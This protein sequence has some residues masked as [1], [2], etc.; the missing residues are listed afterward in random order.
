MI[1]E[2]NGCIRLT[3]HEADI[4]RQLLRT[5]AEVNTIAWTCAYC[6]EPHE[7]SALIWPDVKYRLI[8]SAC[9]CQQ[10]YPHHIRGLDPTPTPRE[11]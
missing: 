8:C 7:T 2:P 3:A 1:L 9:G 5:T 10:D 4:L 11:P 6:A